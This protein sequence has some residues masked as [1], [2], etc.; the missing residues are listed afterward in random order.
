MICAKPGGTIGF[1]F[2]RSL[3]G[4]WPG[5]E[6]VVPPATAGLAAVKA[7][8]IINLVEI[9]EEPAA[10][11]EVFTVCDYVFE[12]VLPPAMAG[13]SVVEAWN[14]LRKRT[15]NQRLSKKSSWRAIMH[16]ERSCLERLPFFLALQ[17]YPI[18]AAD[19]SLK[20]LETFKKFF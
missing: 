11:K 13:L 9:E 4:P 14:S 5:I 17:L 1:K 20:T 8:M 15:R 2:Q 3:H 10:S 18:S 12:V 7:W 19:G 6:A 16:L